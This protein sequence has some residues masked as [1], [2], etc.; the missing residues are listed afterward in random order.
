MR[1]KTA[2]Q[3][4]SPRSLHL[5]HLRR[6][7]LLASHGQHQHLRR[8]RDGLDLSHLPSRQHQPLYL[9]LLRY[10]L[11]LLLHLCLHQLLYQCLQVSHHLLF[12]L[13]P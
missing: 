9:P 12:H 4:R 3:Y 10:R 13:R 5:N 11:S 8:L 1:L 7:L 2:R 6:R